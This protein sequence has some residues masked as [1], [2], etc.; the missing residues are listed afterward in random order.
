[1]KIVRF[2]DGTTGLLVGDQIVDV[3]SSSMLLDKSKSDILDS[4]LLEENERN[5][6]FNK[7]EKM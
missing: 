6:I 1:M 7:Q 5:E 3:I 4:L 2:N